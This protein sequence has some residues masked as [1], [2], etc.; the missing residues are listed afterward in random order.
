MSLVSVALSKNELS[1][2]DNNIIVPFTPILVPVGKLVLPK[3][4]SL[5]LHPIPTVSS[6]IQVSLNSLTLVL[7]ILE[8]AFISLQ[9]ARLFNFK[10]TET[11]VPW[12]W[13]VFDAFSSWSIN[14]NIASGKTVFPDTIKD[15]AS[16]QNHLARILL[17]TSEHGAIISG[18]KLLG[19]GFGDLGSLGN[20][21]SSVWI[22]DLNS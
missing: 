10:S 6:S 1:R 11:T 21:Q 4:L 14:D 9:Y 3:T 15:S 16:I 19:R 2:T 12:L 20:S 8:E 7:S 13:N 22:I 17:E 18:S 5:T